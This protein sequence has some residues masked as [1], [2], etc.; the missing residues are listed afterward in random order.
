[1]I[2]RIGRFG[3][4]VRICWVRAWLCST[5]KRRSEPPPNPS[6]GLQCPGPLADRAQLRISC[7]D[8]RPAKQGSRGERA[9]GS[10][11]FR[12]LVLPVYIV[13]V[14]ESRLKP[15]SADDQFARNCASSA[16]PRFCRPCSTGPPTAG[17]I[18]LSARPRPDADARMPKHPP[19]LDRPRC[20]ASDR[21]PGAG[22]KI[23]GGRVGG[24]PGPNSCLV[25]SV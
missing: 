20:G 9:G 4:H 19:P 14:W 7:A 5:A 16:R 15:S 18:C 1:M 11:R 17:A 25:N 3:L 12:H 13:F 10:G 8:P 6:D 2:A 21:V 22:R 24:R 23:P